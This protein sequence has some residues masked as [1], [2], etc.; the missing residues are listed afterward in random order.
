MKHFP[1]TRLALALTL[2]FLVALVA[3]AP[4]AAHNPGS[5]VFYDVR[6]EGAGNFSRDVAGEA[7][8]SW[9]DRVNITWETHYRNLA[10]PADG[11]V[12]DHGSNINTFSQVGGHWK[13]SYKQPPD[14]G[15]EDFV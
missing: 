8:N 13:S 3:A 4:G 10:L 2:S 1:P 14:S 9:T 6:Y 12:Y 15:N 11:G 5:H 7:G